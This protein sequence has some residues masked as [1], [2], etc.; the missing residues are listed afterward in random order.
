MKFSFTYTGATTLDVVVYFAANGKLEGFVIELILIADSMFLTTPKRNLMLSYLT[1]P[2]WEFAAPLYQ[3][4]FNLLHD[5]LENTFMIGLEQ[6][7]V[8]TIL[9]HY[10]VFA[11]PSDKKLKGKTHGSWTALIYHGI[12]YYGYGCTQFYAFD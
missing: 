6:M 5:V 10:E 11:D 4:T 3:Y 12:A 9:Y 7:G 2:G 8:P 1:Y